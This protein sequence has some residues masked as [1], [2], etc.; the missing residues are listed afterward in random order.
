MD[1]LTTDPPDLGH[2]S[3]NVKICVENV[4]SL[5]YVLLSKHLLHIF[6]DAL[7]FHLLMTR[8]NIEHAKKCKMIN[9]SQYGNEKF[10]GNTIT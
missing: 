5:I 1:F 6:S 3:S 8:K 7:L 9:I 2:R 4:F 10:C